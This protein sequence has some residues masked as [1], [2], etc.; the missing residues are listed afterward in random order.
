MNIHSDVSDSTVGL[1]SIALAIIQTR[2]SAGTV[3]RIDNLFM[4][5]DPIISTDEVTLPESL[6]PNTIFYVLYDR[7][8]SRA[9]YKGQT[10]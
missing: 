9:E 4:C 3:V 5:R 1:T 6:I 7:N 2:L 10:I 8:P